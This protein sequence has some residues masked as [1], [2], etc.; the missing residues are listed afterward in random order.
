MVCAG[1]VEHATGA[2]AGVMEPARHMR[3][4]TRRMRGHME[5]LWGWHVVVVCIVVRVQP[6]G[7]VC[8]RCA[9][10]GTVALSDGRR[11]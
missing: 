2:W 9:A 7:E 6:R 10:S 8:K 5:C 3:R 11:R 1:E 4:Y